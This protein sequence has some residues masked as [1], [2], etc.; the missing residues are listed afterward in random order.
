M[1]RA[2]LNISATLEYSKTQGKS[3][4]T[5]I[6]VYTDFLTWL[7]VGWQ[8]SHRWP[9]SRVWKFLA[10]NV[11]FS[12]RS[13]ISM[14]SLE[15]NL[16]FYIYRHCT[17]TYTTEWLRARSA[18]SDIIAMIR[19]IWRHFRY[20]W[21]VQHLLWSKGYLDVVAVVWRYGF[22]EENTWIKH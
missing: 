1:A 20:L 6:F 5:C 17:A 10:N 11:D 12:E 9:R 8:H 18:T 2:L 21:R 16:P 19:R 15:N 7:L 4:L 22:L 3:R 13:L 14:C